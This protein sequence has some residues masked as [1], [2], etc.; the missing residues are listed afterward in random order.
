MANKLEKAF[1]KNCE[2]YAKHIDA[3]GTK[4]SENKKAIF[5]SMSLSMVKLQFV[6][7]RKNT[8]LGLPSTIFVRVYLNKNNNFFF[9]LP[10]LLSFLNVDDFR[11]CYFP[12]I[13]SEERMDCCFAALTDVLNAHLDKLQKLAGEFR[14]E[15]MRKYQYESVKG[16][17]GLKDEDFEN[18]EFYA[19]M[20]EVFEM[21]Q[22]LHRYCDIAPYYELCCGNREKAIKKYEK[23]VSKNNAYPYEKRLLEYIKKP[24]N[25]EFKPISEECFAYKNGKKYAL[26]PT[27]TTLKGYFIAFIIA[28]IVYV[29][30]NLLITAVTCMGTVASF[31]V[32]GNLC[33]ALLMVPLGTFFIS[34]GFS[35]VLNK[36][37]RDKKH[38]ERNAYKG[39][40]ETS[41]EKN[42]GQI[43]TRSLSVIFL[44]ALAGMSFWTTRVYDTHILASDSI[45]AFKPL[46]IEYE[47]I[48]KIYHMDA[49]Y[50]VY[51]DRLERPSY[52]IETKDGTI[53][54]FDCIT[55]A[56]KTKEKFLPIIK[57]YEI[58]IVNVDSHKEIPNY[59]DFYPNE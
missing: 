23:L 25:A 45:N 52:V 49:R 36:I 16:I 22:Y 39:I 2:E 18:F 34:V 54:D 21:S 46:R 56:E 9:H 53:F 58:E 10:D 43:A 38:A 7:Y 28:L 55:T 24:E 48:E 32:F 31:G 14:A 4:K 40:L 13:E 50:N 27:D 51:G 20:Q 26:N 47:N 12:Y 44:L 57:D 11:A 1:I 15:E 5:Y 59:E 30:T 33:L 29:G 35:D 42:F 17:W 3:F 37:T 41:K 6:Y 8:A 19:K